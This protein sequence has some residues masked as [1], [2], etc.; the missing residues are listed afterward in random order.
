MPGLAAVGAKIT[1]AFWNANRPGLVAVVPT[2]VAGTGVTLGTAGVV[3]LAAATTASINGCFTTTYDSYLVRISST[4]AAGVD[5]TVRLRASGTDASGASTY[6]VTGPSQTGG[7]Q[8]LNAIAAAQWPVTVGGANQIHKT[9]LTIEE[10]AISSQITTLKTRGFDLA[11]PGGTSYVSSLMGYHNVL[12]AF[13]GF[14]L[15]VSTGTLTGS[16][17]IY[18][19]NNL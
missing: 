3:T 9:E 4:S 13:D 16:I 19:Y 15:V 12:A 14:S 6:A 2:S 5:F 11:S 1:A 17:R 8:T 7:T 10:P 18:G